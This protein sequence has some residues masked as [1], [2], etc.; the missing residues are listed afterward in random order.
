M[1]EK[2]ESL[3][4]TLL[5]H[6]V[7]GCEPGP[8]AASLLC[9]EAATQQRIEEVVRSAIRNAGLAGAELVL[10]FVGHG[11]TRGGIPKLFL[12]AGDSRRDEPTTDVDVGE[13][14]TQALDTQGVQGVIALVDTCHAGG[15]TPDIAA[16]G[17]GIRRGAVN[18]ALLMSV[19]VDEGAHGLAFTHGL[20]QVLR[21]GVPGAGSRLSAEDVRDAVNQAMNIS[22][23]VLGANGDPFA[24]RLWLA[25]NN[26]YAQGGEPLGPVGA[27][28]LRGALVSLDEGLL[29][30]TVAGPADL[31]DLRQ[32]LQAL[33]STRT[34]GPDDIAYAL[35]VVDGLLDASRTA[36]LL[37]SWP[38]SALTSERLRR[39]VSAAGGTASSCREAGGGELLRDCVESLRLRAPRVGCSRLAPL[40]AFI[41]VLARED[42]LDADN[43]SIA[44]WAKEAD[45]TIELNDAFEQLAKQQT[46][47]RLRLVVSLHAALADDWPE[48]L[49][50]WLLDDGRPV[51]HREFVC[52][53]SQHGVEQQ[54]GTVLKWA[55][56]QARPIGACLKRV[57]IAASSTLLLRWRP[58]ETNL[59]VRL[60]VLHDVGLRWSDRL[61]VPAHLWWINSVAR[62]QLEA[63]RRGNGGGTPVDW[64]GRSEAGDVDELTRR[65]LDGA[66]ARALALS[67]LPNRMEDSMPLLLALAPI[68]LWP[69]QEGELT[70][71]ARASVERDWHKLPNEFSA[72]YRSTWQQRTERECTEGPAPLARLRS[73]WHDTDWLD[74]CDWFETGT[75]DGENAL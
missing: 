65:V 55:Y 59:G 2:V 64:L 44:R 54:L 57:E 40:A 20:T 30:N 13:L 10:V 9:G 73:V 32:K 62:D 72:A 71:A 46:G 1:E 16:L 18:L 5:D 26:R 47:S 41:A 28:D 14:L 36:G 37:R 15:A 70:E 29:P 43:P 23:R 53:P 67:H 17:T 19:G 52:V 22:A 75:T 48:S 42:G 45:A 35:R 27:E 60:G 7:G 33:A 12:M 4:A 34:A 56:G 8:G 49:L 58:E 21:D 24:G 63:I 51:A 66:H 39:A 31:T 3:H 6:R 69:G 38:G 25:R 74:F 61:S 11:M 50:A 68:L